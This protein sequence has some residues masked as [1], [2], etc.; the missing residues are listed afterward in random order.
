LPEAQIGYPPV[1]A[2]TVGIVCKDGVVLASEKRISYGYS[3]M[4]KAGKKVFLVN[5]RIGVAFAG[6]VSDAQAIL[7]RLGA[8]VRLYELD[9]H[10]RMSVRSAAKLLANILY[11]QRYY[12][13][14]TETI[15]GGVDEEGNRLF[16]L[17]QLGSLIEDKFAALGTGG[18]M[19][20]SVI[21][22]GYKDG[23][24]IEEA[25]E[26][27]VKAVRAAISRDVASGDGVDVAIITRDGAKEEFFPAK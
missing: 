25:K 16:V 11:S 3:I 12:P 14:F 24:G 7:R 22:E 17:D 5:E 27:A 18:A 10:K 8:E 9:Y 1:G 23:M 2:T 21:E 6:L 4:S 26:L 15:V 19:A 20:I 13:V